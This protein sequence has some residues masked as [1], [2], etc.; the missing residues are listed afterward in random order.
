MKKFIYGVAVLLS[1]SLFL[2]GCGDPETGPA[3][4]AGPAGNTKPSVATL[5]ADATPALWDAYFASVD[6]VFLTGDLAAGTFTV[7]SGKTLAVIGDVTLSQASIINAVDGTFD[8]SAGTI[9]ASDTNAMF[10]VKDKAAYT[11]K[12]TGTVPTY[13]SDI[14]A[15]TEPFGE[16]VAVSGF[17]IGEGGVT[18][19]TLT[20][21]LGTN[22]A[23]VV[24]TLA[25]NAATAVDTGTLTIVT[26]GETTA[27]GTG[28]ITLGDNMAIGTL[29][30]VG[31]LTITA[32][33]AGKVETLDLNGQTVT[34]AAVANIE[35]ITNTGAAAT[36]ALGTGTAL[37]EVNVGTND[38]TVTTTGVSLTVADLSSGG[39]KLVIP[40]T[41][42]GF[43]ATLTTGNSA[44]I[45]YAAAPASNVTLTAPSTGKLTYAGDLTL[46][47][48]V[49]LT[50][51]TGLVAFNGNLTAGGITV[52]NG[53]SVTGDLEALGATKISVTTGGLTV[54]G[55]LTLSTATTDAFTVTAGAV[56]IGT[57]VTKAG[58]VATFG[59]VAEIGSL[60]VGA[61]AVIA[62]GALVDIKEATGITATNTLII[63]NTVGVRISSGSVLLA[64]DITAEDVTVKGDSTG[65]TLGTLTAIATEIT[66][67][68]TLAISETAA[69][70]LS[71]ATSK[72]ILNPGAT[73]SV[74]VGADIK[75]E[76][77][78]TEVSLTV[79]TDEAATATKGA[80]A[81]AASSWTV[82]TTAGTGAADSIVLGKI[83]FTLSDNADPFAG[84]DSDPAAAGSVTAG[85][86][87]KLTFAGTGS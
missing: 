81:G 23:Y 67:G 86:G 57:L 42:V 29:K 21:L 53:L 76:D 22:T 32:V 7:P 62:G 45:A 15:I 52:G 46:G 13:V 33:G 35:S 8:V 70:V 51:A 61:G 40:A 28:G 5:P 55:E 82:T 26:F 38:I 54:D 20:T 3:G 72:L 84:A 71:T 4:P 39:G 79:S 75:D 77:D 41:A 66:I 24:G 58:S 10:L 63:K 80:V 87:T 64:A 78:H 85:E 73:L 14:S 36:I 16:D 11:G 37:P 65:V 60:T 47:D 1:V 27:K 49:S 31:E 48:A 68:K 18:I 6:K 59:D 50:T 44:K 19:A 12:I 25:I 2:V 43:T 34:I 83:T 9:T 74:A 69:L 30:A 56:E 17:G